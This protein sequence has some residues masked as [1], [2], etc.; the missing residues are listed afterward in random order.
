MRRRRRRRVAAIVS[1]VLGCLLAPLVIVQNKIYRRDLAMARQHFRPAPTFSARDRVLVFSPHCDDETLGAGGTLAQARHS[2]ARVKVVFFTNGDGSRSTQI[3]ENTKNLRRFS[4]QELAAMRQRESVAAMAELGVARGDVL[5]LGYPD[6]GLRAM[7]EKHWDKNSYRS[8]YTNVTRSP[9]PNA[10]TSQAPYRGLQVLADVEKIMS[11]FEPTIILTTHPADTHGD[12]WAAYAYTRAAIE[13]SRLRARDSDAQDSNGH[14]PQRVQL[15]T[16]LVH[17]GVWPVPHGYHPDARLAPPAK[18]KNCGTQ[19]MDADLDTGA[20]TQ[21]KAALERYTSQLIWTPHYLRAFL[22]RNEIFGQ[23]PSKVL[24]ANREESL[25]CDEGGDSLWQN[26]WPGADIRALCL[27]PTPQGWTL[28][29]QTASR[30]STRLRYEITM[31]TLDKRAAQTVAFKVLWR[32]GTWIARSASTLRGNPQLAVRLRADGLEIDVPSK[33]L[34][35]QV[36]NAAPTILLSAA[37][38]LGQ[39]RLDQTETA[40]IQLS[41]NHKQ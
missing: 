41:A 7:W 2:G 9:Y 16:F 33:V 12:H 21:K 11:E 24:A 10:F 22:R 15:L 38:M 1:G 5:F 3:A 18:M 14:W 30:P 4:F 8:P 36:K 35:T 39:A 23:V 19:W 32:G 28:R 25:L 31:H 34:G 29:I 13:K 17:H 27:R 6:G 40:T 37:A 20:R 26:L